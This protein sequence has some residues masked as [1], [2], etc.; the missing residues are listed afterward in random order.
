VNPSFQNTLFPS[1]NAN[2]PAAKNTVHNFQIALGLSFVP[3]RST[4]PGSS[5]QPQE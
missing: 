4:E 1:A 3:K 2:P 5:D